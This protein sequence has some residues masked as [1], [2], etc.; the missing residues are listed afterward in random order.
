MGK[1]K[2]PASVELT[3]AAL[4]HCI[5]AGFAVYGSH[6]GIPIKSLIV[7]IEGDIDLQGMLALPESGKNGRRFVSNKRFSVLAFPG[8]VTLWMAVAFGD[9]GLSLLANSECDASGGV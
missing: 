4:G 5:S 3:L 8:I 9:M 1:N 6:M 7:E 2:G